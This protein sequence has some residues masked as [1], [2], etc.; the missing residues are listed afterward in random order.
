MFSS[1]LVQL[2][3]LKRFARDF[4]LQNRFFKVSMCSSAIDKE[5]F[6]VKRNDQILEEQSVIISEANMAA[7][8]LPVNQ[9]FFRP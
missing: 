5:H 6:K 9:I 7:D 2:S 3:P 4:L 1:A 8:T